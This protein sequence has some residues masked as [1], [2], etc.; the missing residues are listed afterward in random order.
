MQERL[1]ALFPVICLSVISHT[2][3]T[4]SRMTVSLAAIQ[5][6]APT[7]TVGLLLSLYALLPMLLSVTAGR[8]ID[9]VGTRIPMLLGSLLL[10]VGLIVPT[11]WL[12]IAALFCNSL[13]VGTGFMLFHLCIQ[14]L[15]GEIG[16][17]ADRM[18]NFGHLAVGFSVSAFFGPIIAGYLID[19]AGA[20]VSFGASF[21]A[22]TVLIVVAFALLQWRWTFSGRSLLE[23]GQLPTGGRLLDLLQTAELRRLYVAVV[24]TSTAWD[25]FMFLVPIQGSRIGLTASQIGIVMAAFSVATFSVR[26][27]LPLIAR[28]LS[29]W[30]L[31][32]VVQ[33]MAA[34]VY[35]TVPL[36]GSHYGMIALSFVLG[37]ALGVGQ[38][39]V[40]TILHQVSPP[41]RIGEAVGLRMTLVNG[42][43]TV[44]PTAFGGIG[45]LLSLF[46]VGSMAYAPLYWA[47]ATM[48]GVGGVSAM[49]H[50]TRPVSSEN[51]NGP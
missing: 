2:A 13:F 48:L 6:K 9:R 40:M 33:L 44:L 28:R 30:Q 41:G 14:K 45:S 22:S 20:G 39:T 24:L 42:T 49:R 46:L 51:F 11:L 50:Q 3:F 37:L 8:W 4:A 21:A 34:G 35:L 43:Q 15:T 38:P 32:G 47:V 16:E 1:P 18:R 5:M 29:P 26:M 7:I 12:A 36:I 25:V 27:A 31:I 10:G 23:P 17:G 19:R